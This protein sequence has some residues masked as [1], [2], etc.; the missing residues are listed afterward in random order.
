MRKAAQ[1][2]IGSRGHAAWPAINQAAVDVRINAKVLRKAHWGRGWSAGRLRLQ[3]ALC[4]EREPATVFHT[5]LHRRALAR[6]GASTESVLVE[7]V[8]WSDR[9]G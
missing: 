5:Q 4:A 1:A 9:A 2:G 6:R 3:R 8:D 7:V